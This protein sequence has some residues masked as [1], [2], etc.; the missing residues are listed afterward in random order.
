MNADADALLAS[1]DASFQRAWRA[2]TDEQRSAVGATGFDRYRKLNPHI[3]A[4][5]VIR[6]V[7]DAQRPRDGEGKVKQ[8]EQLVRLAMEIFEIAQTET[9]EAFAL[10]RDGP[11]IALMF[12][13]SRDA[14]RA[15]LAREYRLRNGSTP[16]AAALADALTAL[17]GEALDTAPRPVHL[18]VAR[19]END[20]ILDL[21]RPD[22]RAVVVRPGGWE[23]R[24]RSPVVFRRSALTGELPIPERGG[25]MEMLRN[26]IR[27]TGDTWPLALGWEIAAYLPVIPHPVL[28]LGGEQG[29]GKTTTA[30]MLVALVDPSPAPV[31][32]QPNDT[33]AWA[34]A[35]SGSWVVAVDNVSAIPAWWSDCICKAVTGDGLVRRKL[36]TDSELSVLAFRR[37]I[38][39][40]SIDAGALRG[41]LGDRILFA[42]LDPIPAYR[43]RSEADLDA[44]FEAARPKILGALLDVLAGVLQEL[45]RVRLAELPRMADFG[46]VLAA[47]DSAIG[48]KALNAYLAQRGRVV[49]E[50]LDGDAI[51]GNIQAL[52]KGDGWAGTA[53]E[54]LEHITPNGPRP[55]AWPGSPRALVA[56]LMRLAP[57]LRQAGVLMIHGERVGHDRRRL[58]TIKKAG[59]QPSAPSA[60]TQR[61]V[62][63]ADGAVDADGLL[64]ASN[65]EVVA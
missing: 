7:H 65:N 57:A 28:L 22:G 6:L 32:S 17:S 52:A 36:Y 41:D 63:S 9:G 15:T 26:I 27:V 25:S 43:R 48:T 54:L 13:G 35:A 39:L 14:L 21:G 59:E 8:S 45:P 10:R 16:N 30:R 40:T 20:L 2:L 12:R 34:V 24:D 37:V 46:R 50:V 61:P 5:P 60:F 64:P 3:T 58:I 4:A 33:E 51:A 23:V 18:R 56:R 49:S 55:H 29:A 42:D 11:P 38:I 1:D 19:Y 53:A 62:D 44:A 31:R 47:M